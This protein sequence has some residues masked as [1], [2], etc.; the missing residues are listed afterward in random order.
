MGEDELLQLQDR[1]E[2]VRLD[3]RQP[4]VVG[5]VDGAEVKVVVEGG[6]L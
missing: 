2:G 5:E 4:G 1:R 3:V 6:D